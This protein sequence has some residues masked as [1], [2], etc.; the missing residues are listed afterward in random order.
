MNRESYYV[1]PEET[2]QY[3]IEWGLSRVLEQESKNFSLNDSLKRKLNN[4]YDFNIREAFNLIDQENLG[5]LEFFR[6][7][8]IF[9]FS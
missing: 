2:L 3:E 1:A 4:S 7:I 6:F 8:H 9:H 5:Y